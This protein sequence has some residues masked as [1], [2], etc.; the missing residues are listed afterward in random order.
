[1]TAAAAGSAVL[2]AAAAFVLLL[3]LWNA[4]KESR[5]RLQAASAPDNFPAR[6]VSLVRVSLDSNLLPE[7]G[8]GGLADVGVRSRESQDPYRTVAELIEWLARESAATGYAEVSGVIKGVYQ[9]GH[10]L[11]APEAEVRH[12]LQPLLARVK[13]AKVGGSEV[14]RVE[15]VSTGAILDP[16]TMAPLN[17]GARV[18]QPLGVLVYDSGGKVLGKAKVLCG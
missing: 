17:Y 7:A 11:R 2:I 12:C 4:D 8:P 18:T 14:G 13:A 6:V 9:L 10:T 16:G 15:C 3:R 5:A 1:M